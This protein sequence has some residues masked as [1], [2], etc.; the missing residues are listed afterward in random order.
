MS[1]SQSD[2][3]NYARILNICKSI[4]NIDVYINRFK[5]HF[6]V[7]RRDNSGTAANYLKGLFCCPKGEANMERIEEEVS[8][9][10]YR[11]Y[12]HF[13]SNSKWDWE[14]LQTHVAQEASDL[15]VSQ[16][17]RNNFPIGYII[18][19]SSHLKKGKKS[20]G[21]SRQYAGVIG[22][23][24]NCQ[25]GVY[26]SL[27]NHTN[28]PLINERL[29]LP[30][31]WADD[32]TRCEEAT[33]PDDQIIHKTKPELALEMIK[34][35]MDRGVV[36]DWVGG[37]GLYGHNTQLRDGLDA[38]KLFYVLDLHKDE[39][40]FLEQPTFA[41]PQKKTGR[42]RKPTRLQSNQE[43]IRLDKLVQTLTEDHWKLEEIR[44]TTKG[45]LRLYVHKQTVWLWDGESEKTKKKTLIITKT[46]DKK[47]KIKYSISNGD[48]QQYTHKEYAYFVSQRYWVERTFDNAKNELGMSDYQVR[49]WQSW[50]THHAIIMLASLYIETNMIEHREQ[51]ELL[52]FRDVRIMVVAQICQQQIL[53]E[54]KAKQ[55]V[56]RH[57]KRKVDMDYAARKQR[58]KLKS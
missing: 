48:L 17:N 14:G 49:K 39:K 2:K 9:S 36:F 40:V 52:S 34:Q 13:I 21:V 10:E 3:K 20:V 58:E 54:K 44:D 55:M 1:Q 25:V 47:P 28:A 30:E 26:A 16:K 45:K 6:K 31:C 12:Q 33:I 27:V 24:D 46:T 41:V 29:F 22:K 15:L 43:S 35:D 53:F 51:V 38:L 5:K 11:A 18:D 19:E 8:G 42:G 4:T 32:A 23:V 50:H 57:K 37:D 7:Y 56:K